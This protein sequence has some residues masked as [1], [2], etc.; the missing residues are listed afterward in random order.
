MKTFHVLVVDD[1]KPILDL[2]DQAQSEY[3]GL[4]VSTAQTADEA[5]ELIA[6]C[7]FHVALVDLQLVKDAKG[8]DDGLTVLRALSKVRP[9]CRRL[10]LTN[11]FDG[12]RHTIYNMLVPDR[13]LIDGVVD[14]IDFGQIF[15]DQFR[16]DAEVWLRAPVEV[17]G[18]DNIYERVGS[19][20]IAVQT[21]FSVP[22]AI[23]RSEVDYLVSALFG[24]GLLGQADETSDVV[25]IALT[26]LDGGKSRSVVA[27]GRPVD[28]SGHEGINCVVKIG[29]RE[30]TL[31]ELHRYDRYVRFRL[32]L[33]RRVE[34][35]GYEIGDTLGVICYSF[36]GKSPGSITDLQTLLNEHEP[37][38][39][40]V[41]KHLLDDEGEW[42]RNGNS[43]ADIAGFFRKAYALDGER[44]VERIVDF[45]RNHAAEFDGQWDDGAVVFKGGKIT[46]PGR[47][48]LGSGH[49]RCR[50]SESIVHGDLNAG[51]VIVSSDDDVTLIDFRHT[52]RGPV[53]L[54]LAALHASVRLTP[55]EGPLTGQQILADSRIERRLWSPSFDESSEWWPK[56]AADRPPYWAEVSATLIGIGSRLGITHQE[57]IVTMLLYALRVAR[58]KELTPDARMRLL[59]WIAALERALAELPD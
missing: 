28:Q 54:D 7:F 36:A 58:V 56:R 47:E 45:A 42:H 9:T 35:L 22:T 51:N 29:P 48:L 2:A 20:R 11:Q 3:P 23:T 21:S 49:L 15:V 26:P 18:L 33:H 32:S 38:V 19:K 4:V 13:R 46:L 40:G 12:Y 52:T 37:R 44:V 16:H 17:V 8:N 59:V 5:H 6:S 53:A 39:H 10:L 30:D 34:M 14:K 43:V 1:E 27:A 55:G 24:Q 50:Y 31:E 41:I 57:H 25:S